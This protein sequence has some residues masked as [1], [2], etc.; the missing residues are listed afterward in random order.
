MRLLSEHAN[1]FTD[2]IMKQAMDLIGR[3]LQLCT[4]ENLEVR[5]AANDLLGSLIR[6]VSDNIDRNKDADIR[7]FKNIMTQFDAILES[8]DFKNMQLLSAIRAVGIFSKAIQVILGD[9]KLWEYL[10]K[11]TELSE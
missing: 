9:N 4:Q 2:Q 5:D 1:L 11:L 6:L 3:T 10:N 7:L 8:N